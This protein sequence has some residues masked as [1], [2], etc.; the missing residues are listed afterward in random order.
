MADRG[1]LPDRRRRRAAGGLP[2]LGMC[3]CCWDLHGVA[4]SPRKKG[5]TSRHFAAVQSLVATGA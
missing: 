3:P 5:V 4:V 1:G 2:D